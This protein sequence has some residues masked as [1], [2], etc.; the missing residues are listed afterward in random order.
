MKFVTLCSALVLASLCTAL[1]VNPFGPSA[2]SFTCANLQQMPLSFGAV[3]NGQPCI[4]VEVDGE[5]QRFDTQNLPVKS[6][7]VQSS[8]NLLVALGDGTDSDGLYSFDLD[9]HQWNLIQWF[10][11]PNFVKFNPVNSLYYLGDNTG[12]YQSDNVSAWQHINSIGSGQSNSLDFYENYLVV[13]CGSQVFYS[14]DSGVS[15]SQANGNNLS[16]FHYTADTYLFSVMHVGSDSDGIWCSADFGQSWFACH[17]CSCVCELGPDFNGCLTIGRSE[18]DVPA[19]YVALYHPGE[20]IC[21]CNHVSLDSPV[22]QLDLFPWVD[23]P[24]FYVVN[25]QGC[26][27]ITD[28]LTDNEDALIPELLRPN[29][30]VYPNPA[31]SYASLKIA[32]KLRGNEALSLYNLKGQLI[33]AIPVSNDVSGLE[34]ISSLDLADLP[35]GIYLLCLRDA[36]ARKLA[37]HKVVHL[38]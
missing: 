33:R 25:G 28:F 21:F 27:I 16:D 6:I 5:W 37:S 4:F 34:R 2:D 17:Y 20:Q 22:K 11:D 31:F 24:S 13:N 1:Q 19:Q 30:S 23:T 8:N 32:G 26:F 15:W 14:A 9:S 10:S 3:Y 18:S 7:Y 38:K 12:L 29:L 35:A 36:N